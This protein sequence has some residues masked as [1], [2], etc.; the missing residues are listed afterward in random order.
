MKITQEQLGGLWSEVKKLDLDS[1]DA[2]SLEEIDEV[3]DGQSWSRFQDVLVTDAKV[4]EA[5]SL[6]KKISDN[7]DENPELYH[8]AVMMMR[9]MYR[10]PETNDTFRKLKAMEALRGDEVA[11]FH[12]HVEID[13]EENAVLHAELHAAYKQIN[14]THHFDISDSRYRF[15]HP[16]LDVHLSYRL[17]ADKRQD[18]LAAQDDDSPRAEHMLVTGDAPHYTFYVGGEHDL[19]LPLHAIELFGADGAEDLPHE[20]GHEAFQSAA[21]LANPLGSSGCDFAS[22][23]VDAM[24][25]VE[26]FSNWYSRSAD[27]DNEF[28]QMPE[29]YLANNLDLRLDEMDWAYTAVN[30]WSLSGNVDQYVRGTLAFEFL[31]KQ[32]GEEGVWKVVQELQAG[33]N[34]NAALRAATNDQWN[35]ERFYQEEKAYNS[36]QIKS[37]FSFLTTSNDVYLMQKM[38]EDFS[39]YQKDHPQNSD[40]ASFLVTRLDHAENLLHLVSSYQ[41]SLSAATYWGV[42]LQVEER[43][44]AGEPSQARNIFLNVLRDQKESFQT[45]FENDAKAFAENCKKFRFA[46][47]NLNTDNYQQAFAR[48]RYVPWAN[49]EY[50]QVQEK[51]SS[52]PKAALQKLEEI[53][54]RKTALKKATGLSF[55]ASHSDLDE[56]V[57]YLD[58]V[59]PLLDSGAKNFLKQSFADFAERTRAYPEKAFQEASGREFEKFFAAFVFIHKNKL[60]TSEAQFHAAVAAFL[61][62]VVDLGSKGEPFQSLAADFF[63]SENLTPKLD[64]ENDKRSNN[65]SEN[66]SWFLDLVREGVVNSPDD[67]QYFGKALAPILFEMVKDQRSTLK[68]G[69][70]F[71][72][73]VAL[74][75]ADDEKAK[76]L[77]AKLLRYYGPWQAENAEEQALQDFVEE[78]ILDLVNEKLK[79]QPE[80]LAG[81][82]EWVKDNFSLSV[83]RLSPTLLRLAN[84]GHLVKIREVNSEIPNSPGWINM[85]GD[86]FAPKWQ[87]FADNPE[88]LKQFVEATWEYANLS[89]QAIQNE[90]PSKVT[91]KLQNLLVALC[92]LKEHCQNCGQEFE[93][94]MQTSLN[95]SVDEVVN[96]SRN[97]FANDKK[98]Q[99]E[100]LPA[101]QK[102]SPG[103]SFEA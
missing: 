6:F 52:D 70:A 30:E 39:E 15:C 53:H 69:A 24:W 32:L 101:L 22:S 103:F 5:Y 100:A 18:V 19:D 61:N 74:P 11:C 89:W 26:G 65:P 27:G 48:N 59:M 68:T 75:F 16:D 45:E 14:K 79:R 42:L 23:A 99:D 12:A 82:I 29:L 60:Y 91:V 37:T 38:F 31:Q 71:W 95:T 63:R 80:D 93:V 2:V 73:C 28:L 47:P 17:S 76:T 49:A 102:L 62:C 51:W 56:D 10:N 77:Q 78:Q 1:D 33:K 96:F 67:F 87:D 72:A 57:Q 21:V 35:A 97:I 83:Q 90:D 43:L 13:G 50:A 4:A 46:Y 8:A 34:L 92:D 86:T 88:L 64:L 41:N 66:Q 94:K 81:S 58:C 84:E 54:V 40:L 9:E 7:K 25:L 3:F 36:K 55:F 98:A 85:Y 44:L 20:L